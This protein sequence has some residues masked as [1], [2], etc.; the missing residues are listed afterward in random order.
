MRDKSPR[1]ERTLLIIIIPMP[2]RISIMSNGRRRRQGGGQKM[3]V[4]KHCDCADYK[5]YQ[6][7]PRIDCNLTIR[8]RLASRSAGRWLITSLG[9]FIIRVSY[10]RGATGNT[11]VVCQSKCVYCHGNHLLTESE[12]SAVTR[13]A[14]IEPILREKQGTAAR[15]EI[16]TVK[17]F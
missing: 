2:R 3:R 12:L 9:G 4:V 13:G 8:W 11:L 6:L 7:F 10:L 16:K 17:R 14:I 1:R 5:I 15:K